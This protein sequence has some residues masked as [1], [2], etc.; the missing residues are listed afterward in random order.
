MTAR[1]SHHLYKNILIY[2]LQYYY[3]ICTVFILITILNSKSSKWLMKNWLKRIR[4]I[5]FSSRLCY[6]ETILSVFSFKYVNEILCYC[7][8]NYWNYS[9]SVKLLTVLHTWVSTLL[10]SK[11]F[12]CEKKFKSSSDLFGDYWRSESQNSNKTFVPIAF[13]RIL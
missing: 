1:T 11:D 10:D 8:S 3:Y 7:H 12:S 2:S 5:F 9:L 4:M 13:Q 6:G